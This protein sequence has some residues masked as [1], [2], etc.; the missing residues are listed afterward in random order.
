M[1]T[2]LAVQLLSLLLSGPQLERTMSMEYY[3]NLELSNSFY[4]IEDRASFA[5]V[6]QILEEERIYQEH[7]KALE[8][9]IQRDYELM[10]E[11]KRQEEAARLEEE[12]KASIVREY[13][14]YS[15]VYITSNLTSS[16][17]GQA[18][19]NTD[20]A[21]LEDYFIEAEKQYGINAVFLTAIAALESGWGSSDYARQRN[22]LFGYGAYDSNP[23]NALYFSS[24]Q[25]GIL[26]VAEKI[27]TNYLTSSGKYYNGSTPVGVNVKYCS[28][29]SW[30][31]KVVSLM[32]K[33]MDSVP[34]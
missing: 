20:L 17:L 13:N 25:D 24:K 19:I 5:E 4:E 28:Q 1:K 32:N 9:Q 27:T 16:E 7:L 22:N 33:I 8:E 34:Y 2:V 6:D 26:K 21:G 31:S 18:L 11:K 12:R 14:I 23:D 15:N 10:E 3:Q 30:S 29:D